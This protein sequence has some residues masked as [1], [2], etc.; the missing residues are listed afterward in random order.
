MYISLYWGYI[1]PSVCVCTN[2]R[3]LEAIWLE[4]KSF[5]SRPHWTWNVTTNSPLTR[6]AIGPVATKVGCFVGP[7]SIEVYTYIWWHG[8]HKGATFRSQCCPQVLSR[9]RQFYSKCLLGALASKA[10]RLLTSYMI[11]QDVHV[12]QNT[13]NGDRARVHVWANTYAHTRSERTKQAHSLY[14]ICITSWSYKCSNI[15]RE[16]VHVGVCP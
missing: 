5:L 13:C 15:Q 3:W 7:N 16:E 6:L 8:E 12:L 14:T 2:G 9:R 4:L 1:C 10:A 11:S